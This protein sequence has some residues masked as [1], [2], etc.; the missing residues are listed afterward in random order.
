MQTVNL[1]ADEDYITWT[2]A[3]NNTY[4]VADAYEA[5][6]VD[7]APTPLFAATWDVKIKG[8]VNFFSFGY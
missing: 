1:L 3:S 4:S 6:F 5:C 8:K 7:R 2:Q